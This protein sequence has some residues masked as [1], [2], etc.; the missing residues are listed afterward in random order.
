MLGEAVWM[1]GVG[2]SNHVSPVLP[3]ANPLADTDAQSNPGDG[4]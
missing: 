3:V 1:A 4:V 2:P